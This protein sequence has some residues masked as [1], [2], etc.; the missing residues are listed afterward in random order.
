MTGFERFRKNGLQ[1][2]PAFQENRMIPSNTAMLLSRLSSFASA[3]ILA[4]FLFPALS[5]CQQAPANN[6]PVMV[7]HKTPTCGC[8]SNWIEHVKAAGFQ[9]E[10][11]DHQNLTEIKRVNGVAPELQSCHTATV[12]GYVVEGH[13]PADQIIRLITEKPDIKGIAV[14][15]MPIGSPGMEQGGTVQPYNVVAFDG[16]G[17]AALYKHVGS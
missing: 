6:L 3:V 2:N 8:C 1:D 5:G 4:C 11:H 14:P 13:V 15:G 12:G 9:V 17:N 10:V 16:A 7:V